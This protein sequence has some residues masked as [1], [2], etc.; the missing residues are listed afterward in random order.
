MEA[1]T[2]TPIQTIILYGFIIR[3]V[4]LIVAL[5]LAIGGIVL[6]V[7]GIG[8]QLDA[9]GKGG[10]FSLKFKGLTPGSLLLVLGAGIIVA[11]LLNPIRYTRGPSIAMLE[12]CRAVLA[13]TTVSA[14]ELRYDTS[15][16]AGGQLVITV[17]PRLDTTGRSA[18]AL[19][20]LRDSLRAD[21]LRRDST[22]RA[23]LEQMTEGIY[24]ATVPEGVLIQ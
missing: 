1:A 13:S 17:R 12:Q 24:G 10:V 16:A 8:A 6:V 11:V 4:I 22:V 21:S 23:C 14:T 5:A 9:E 3:I 2:M 18:T 15:R 7:K 20:R 19:A